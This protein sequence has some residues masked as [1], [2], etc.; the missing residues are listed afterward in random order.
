MP[1]GLQWGFDCAGKNIAA[2]LKVRESCRGEPAV[3][4]ET[5]ESAFGEIL[6]V[7]G[8]AFGVDKV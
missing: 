4:Y 2:T 8:D 6:F 1:E 3:F 7:V 5:L